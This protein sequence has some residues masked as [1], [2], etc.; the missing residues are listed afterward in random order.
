VIRLALYA[1]TGVA[2][3]VGVFCGLNRAWAETIVAAM[4]VLICVLV[5]LLGFK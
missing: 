1:V 3:L 4:T 2:A 5:L